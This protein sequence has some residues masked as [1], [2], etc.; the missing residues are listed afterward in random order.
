[1][2]V[3]DTDRIANMFFVNSPV[4]VQCDNV[5]PQTIKITAL[6]YHTKIESCDTIVCLFMVRTIGKKFGCRKKYTT[7]PYLEL[8]WSSC[9]YKIYHHHLE[10][11]WSKYE[12]PAA[13][14]ND[15]VESEVQASAV[16]AREF[17]CGIHRQIHTGTHFFTFIS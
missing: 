6:N 7:R 15:E 2:R 3:F 5:V 4:V 8:C 1:M 9:S 11:L 13:E 10:R 17:R 16:S 14:L 12:M